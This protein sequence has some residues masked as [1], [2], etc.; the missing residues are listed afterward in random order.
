MLNRAVFL[1]R[2]GVINKI[3]YRDGKPT[4]PRNIEEFEFEDGIENALRR[5]HV[6]GFKIFI[7]TNQ[8]ELI[9]GLLTKEA[10]M[11]MTDRLVNTFKIDEISICLHDEADHCKCRKPEP[12]ML[13][14]LARKYEISMR[15]SYIIGDSAKDSSAGAS[16]GCRTIILDRKYN[17]EALADWRVPDLCS[18]VDL[19]CS[20]QR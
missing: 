5:L 8:P 13:L 20:N 7:V 6:A 19:I 17:R 14:D 18:A 9:R 10:L 16:A 3:V 12:G 1:D 4:S 11:V 15:D 2:D